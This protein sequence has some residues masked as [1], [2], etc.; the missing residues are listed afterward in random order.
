[1]GVLSDKELDLFSYFAKDFRGRTPRDYRRELIAFK[2]YIGK[3]LLEADEENARN[4]IR[5][6]SNGLEAVSYDIR[7]KPKKSSG[8]I[9]RIY[10]QLYGFYQ[11][12]YENDYIGANPFQGVERPKAP[13]QVKVERTPDFKDMEKLLYT[14]EESFEYRDYLIA[15]TIATTGLRVSQVL[16]IKWNDIIMDDLEH[17]GVGIYDKRLRETRHVRILDVVWEKFKIY[18]ENYLLVGEDIYRKDA[19]VF[20]NRASLDDYRVN[21]E[22]VDSLSDV[23]VRTVLTEACEV[24][25]IKKYTSK[26]LRH[27]HAIYSFKFG[28][29][30]GEV[31]EQLGWSHG[32]LVYRYKGVIEQ[33]SSPANTYTE[34]YFKSILDNKKGEEE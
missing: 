16:N 28:A 24:A 23:T 15:L 8:T 26:D 4:Y 5:D 13:K 17:I 30:V 22:S 25:N 20:I 33:I 7:Y 31:K 27:A 19:Y 29:S 32:N 12:M 3:D 2:K 18:R 14:L 1:M 9:L 11:S 10:H 21:P 34:G 6:L